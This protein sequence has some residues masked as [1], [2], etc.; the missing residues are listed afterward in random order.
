MIPGYRLEGHALVSADE[1]I[2]AADGAMP[3]ELYCEADWRRFQAALDDSILVVVGR[4]SHA[5]RP[6]VRG[7]RR[8]VVS[9]SASG[10]EQRADAWWWN[11]SAATL[12]EA[13]AAAAP[14]GG[15]VGITGGRAVFDL[16]ARLGFDA[17]DLARA[18][19]VR[20]PGGVPIFSGLGGAVDAAAVLKGSGLGRASTEILDAEADVVLD[21][22]L[23]GA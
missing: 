16:F 23:R 19:R 20:L 21:R 18:R 15:R 10:I 5:A 14:E 3:P 22:W 6:N 8:M 7:R 17:F 13:L 2:A 9:S 12:A 1:C 11:P 4:L